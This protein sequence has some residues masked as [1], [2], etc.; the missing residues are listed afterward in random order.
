[1]QGGPAKYCM[2]RKEG[3]RKTN[4]HIRGKQAPSTEA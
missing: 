3:V 4:V 1:M 2:F